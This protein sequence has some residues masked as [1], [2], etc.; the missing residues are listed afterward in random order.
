MSLQ[1]DLVSIE[2]RVAAI[3]GEPVVVL[4]PERVEAFARLVVP[5]SVARAIDAGAR[6]AGLDPA[7]V[8]AVVQAESG[9]NPNARSAAGAQGAMQLMPDTARALGVVD[10]YDPM[11]NVRGGADYLRS[12]LDRFGDLKSAIAAYNAGPGAVARYGGIPPYEQTRVYVDRVME[13]YRANVR[14]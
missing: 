9:G 4:A 14:R 13:A 10:P 7:L 5:G 11:Q 12:L 8:A 1:A 2:R 3:A 6:H